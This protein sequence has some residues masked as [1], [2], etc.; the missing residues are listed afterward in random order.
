MK[1]ALYIVGLLSLFGLSASAQEGDPGAPVIRKIGDLQEINCL[2]AP[3][4]LAV[5]VSNWIPGFTYLWSNV[6]NDSV[7]YVKPE[8]TSIYTVNVLHNDLGFNGTLSFLVQVKNDPII[9]RNEVISIDKFTCPG[10]AIELSISPLG[11][12]G[13][14]RYKWSN[15]STEASTTVYPTQNATFTV[16]VT[17]ACMSRTEATVSVNFEEHDPLQLSAEQ[18]V[19]YSC[20]GK[21]IDIEPDLTLVEGGVG[22]GYE[23]TFDPFF[24]NEPI[25]LL[26]GDLE[27]IK[28]LITDACGVQEVEQT[29]HLIQEDFEPLVLEPISAC[30]DQ[31]VAITTLHD[32]FYYWDGEA[33]R[34]STS[35]LVEE[36]ES[37]ELIYIDECGNQ[38][39]TTQ[40]VI[41][42]DL[43]LD[44]QLDIDHF[45]RTLNAWT[46]SDGSITTIQWILNEEVLGTSSSIDVSE[47]NDDINKLSVTA[48]SSE[49]CEYTATREVILRDGIEVVS[50]I[51]PNG[52]G[53]NDVFRVHIPEAAARFN[54]KIFDRWGQ[55]IYE[56]N[57]QYF[58]WS[59]K[60]AKRIGPFSTFA[61]VIK[62][63]TAGGRTIE[64]TGV[65]TCI[66][67]N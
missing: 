67:E 28:V 20:A 56:S 37:Y 21:Y 46:V 52:D 34:P 32:Q 44:I 66:N 50:A 53:L 41:V 63:V 27:S 17:D 35:I 15:G 42:D 18:E 2:S 30:P 58:E 6:S 5:E 61:Y 47:L 40:S 31:E 29:I 62:A 43:T 49:G 23:Y 33:M 55:L 12:L 14:Y 25:T 48:T 11:G 65:L 22:H 4:P 7:I 8:N 59:S 36:S 54:V 57:D 1:K 64:K 3:V 19:Y 38:Q 39:I 26:S 60:D 16:E 10:E 51:S 9:A 45:E 13:D 24:S